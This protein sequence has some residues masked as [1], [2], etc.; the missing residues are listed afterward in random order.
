MNNEDPRA[1]RRHLLLGVAA[2]AV[3]V[4]VLA[5]C[6]SSDSNTSDASSSSPSTSPGDSTTPSTGGS[7]SGSDVLVKTSD[8][9]VG[10]AV[11][12]DSPNV[13]VTQPTAGD[14]HAFDRTCTHAKCPVTEISDGKIKCTCHG[15]LYD[16]TTGA[17]VSGPAPSPLTAI[18][19]KVEGKNIVQ[20]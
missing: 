5:A 18:D 20:A 2:G 1:S 8:I 17:N 16:M 14:F 19:I 11:F 15:S 9:E 12:L 4:P 6:G 3:G 7:T 10:G 13:V